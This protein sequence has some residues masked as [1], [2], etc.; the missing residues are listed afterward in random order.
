MMFYGEIDPDEIAGLYSQCH[1]GIVSLDRRHKTHNIPGKFLSYMHCG[2]P[3]L[4]IVNP[5]NDLVTMVEEADVGV[6]CTS[7]DLDDLAVQAEGLLARLQS[8]DMKQRCRALAEQRFSSKAA[9]EMIVASL[10]NG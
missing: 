5:G 3:V 4:A 10:A 2:L 6:T 9:V 8:P 1:V 7:F